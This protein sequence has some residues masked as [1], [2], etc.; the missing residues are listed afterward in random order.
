MGAALR[1]RKQ[2]SAPWFDARVE[3]YTPNRLMAPLQKEFGFTLDACA[4]DESAKCAR[5]FTRKENGLVQPWAGERVWCNPPF[6]DIRSWVGKAWMEMALGEVKLIA[7][8]LPVW[9]DRS[10]WTDLV[11]P[12]RDSRVSRNGFRLATRFIPG[13]VRFGNPDDLEGLEVGQPNFWC[14]LLV[15]EKAARSVKTLSR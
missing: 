7:M 2:K 13:R 9:T 8:L 15:W 12:Y 10:W 14:C 4:T 6:N 5:Y 1:K 3:R 11:E